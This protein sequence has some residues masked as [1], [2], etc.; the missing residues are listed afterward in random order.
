MALK[1]AE[2]GCMLQHTSSMR[3]ANVLSA[4]STLYTFLTDEGERGGN[5][6]AVYEAS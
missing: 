1:L 2:G 4:A 3:Y 6:D 5:S